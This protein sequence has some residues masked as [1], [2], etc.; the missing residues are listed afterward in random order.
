MTAVSQLF[1]LCDGH[2]VHTAMASSTDKTSLRSSPYTFT[3]SGFIN[4]REK[5]STSEVTH[6]VPVSCQPAAFTRNHAVV[7]DHILPI[8]IITSDRYKVRRIIYNISSS[9]EG[10]FV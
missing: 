9:V 2:V 4:F 5:G 8:N 10:T 1:N 6:Q 3:Q 7:F